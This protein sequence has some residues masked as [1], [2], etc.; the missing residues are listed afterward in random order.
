MEYHFCGKYVEL[1]TNRSLIFPNLK[2]KAD[3]FFTDNPD[4]DKFFATIPIRA[5]FKND[6]I[7][8]ISAMIC[9]KR[10]GFQE[11]AEETKKVD[12][13]NKPEPNQSKK[14]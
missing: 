2:E 7:S 5:K 14:K 11:K 9:I 4:K 12:E 8:Q 6:K 1:E 3:K 10:T 13:K